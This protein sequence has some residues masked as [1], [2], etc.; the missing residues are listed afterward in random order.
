MG[1]GCSCAAEATVVTVIEDGQPQA[2]P[3]TVPIPICQ[4]GDGQIQGHTA[5]CGELPHVAKTASSFE[6]LK[7]LNSLC[8][9]G[10]F[11]SNVFL[12][13][14][15]LRPGGRWAHFIIPQQTSLLPSSI[16][17]ANLS[18]NS[19]FLEEFYVR[20]SSVSCSVAAGCALDHWGGGQPLSK[21]TNY[22]HAKWAWV[23]L[24]LHY[25]RKEDKGGPGVKAG[26]S[27][28]GHLE[29]LF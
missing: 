23:A 7:H 20:T 15:F 28:G 8:L 11:P 1:V 21:M 25:V 26:V 16:F 3:T 4:I 9:S 6:W 10:V 2:V 19:I 29:R 14:L 13:S 27:I 18:P 12:T 17:L 22:T 24:V 5:P